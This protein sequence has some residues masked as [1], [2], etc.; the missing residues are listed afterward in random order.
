MIDSTYILLQQY[1]WFI[2]SLLGAL[3]VFL[4]FV[5]GGQ[6]L[7]YTI[8]KTEIE[9]K[10]LVNALG[11]KWEYTF[12]TLV[13][14]GGAFFASFPLFYST[15]F[16]GAYWVWMAILFCFIIQAISYEYRSK[17]N[18][19]LGQRTY[20][21]FLFINGLLGTILLG[22]AVATFFT[23]SQFSVEKMNL[24]NIANPI[25]SSWET[26]WHGLEAALNV[27][28]LTLGL[29]VFFLARILGL[30]YFMNYINDE[31]ILARAKK[32]LLYNAI[33]FLVFF[34][35]FTVWL[36]LRDGFAVNPDTK[37]VFM[38]PYK[39]LHNL[40]EMPL[41][42][43]TFLAGVVLVLLG[44]GRSL[45]TSCTKGIWFTG[46]GTILTVLSL[47]LIAGYNN[48]AYYPSTFNL[49]HS[50]TIFNSSSSKFTLSVMSIVSIL[51]PF[52]ATYIWFAWRA[53]TRKKIDAEEMGTESHTY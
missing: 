28:N 11:R 36:L 4:L 13:T 20:E 29:A 26:P 34:L 25:I 48:T 37:E 10:M 31:A 19:F 43:I 24:T 9:R 22:T 52:V 50:L 14:F 42:L 16:G 32:N 17:P 39:Y 30:L 27:H 7:I 23:G 2:I 46:A 49:Q 21:T 38:Q 12:T 3:L 40:I 41:V 33:P 5:Q 1:W 45:F 51:I 18:N 6:T 8:G 47:F 15:S 53:I 44:I 35:T